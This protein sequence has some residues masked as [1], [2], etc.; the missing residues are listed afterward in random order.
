LVDSEP[1]VPYDHLP[2]RSAPKL[3]ARSVLLFTLFVST[4]VSS[5]FGVTRTWTGAVSATWS[6][7]GNWSPA[8]VPSASDAL[9]FPAAASNKST[10]NDLGAGFVVGALSFEGT[11]TL[12][13][14]SL[15][16]LGDVNATN[17][18]AV[19]L[20]INAGVKLGASLHLVSGYTAFTGAVDVNGKVLSIDNNGTS[21]QGALNGSGSVSCPDG[22]AVAVAHGSFSGTLACSVSSQFMQLSNGDVLKPDSGFLIGYGTIGAVNVATVRATAELFTRS[23]TINMGAFG[24]KVGHNSTG[25]VGVTGTVTLNSPELQVT[26]VNGGGSSGETYVIIQNDGVDPII[27]TF[28]GLPEGAGVTVGGERYSISYRGGNGASVALTYRSRTSTT[29]SQSSA[30]SRYGEPVTLIATTQSGSGG[31][32]PGSLRFMD[33][34]SVLGT[35]SPQPSQSA[36]LNVASLEPGAHS[37]TASYLGSQYFD[38]STSTPVS[39]TVLRGSTNCSIASNRASALYGEVVRFNVAV[40]AQAPA[41]GQPAGTV[42]ILE[43]GAAIG[44]APVAGGLA[45]L[46]ARLRPGTKSITAAY[47]GDVHFE[48]SSSAAITQTVGKAPTVI[49]TGLRNP[50]YIGS[51]ATVNLTVKATTTSLFVP[52]GE[53]SVTEGAVLLA[54]QTLIGGSAALNLGTLPAGAH[55][56]RVA[57][58]GSQDFEPSSTTAVQVVLVPAISIAGTRVMEGTGGTTTFALPITLSAPISLPVRVSFFTMP[59]TATEGADYEKTAGVIEF[60]PGEQTKT[61]E[62]HVVADP[63]LENDETFSVLL[64]SPTG[65]TLDVASAVVVIANDDSPPARR[66][67]SRH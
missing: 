60:A 63:L 53:V 52:A 61:I 50:L 9:T 1:V 65:A 8:G 56:L 2:V 27:G 51:A 6:N 33:G 11:Y 40:S 55:E 43:D 67:P 4:F 37:V 20:T 7:S 12:N 30:T 45:S 66:R 42:T 48:A 34:G 62:V 49:E 39:H 31:G 38:E 13:G 18:Q 41:A 46:E 3:M 47:A 26:L 16:L 57:Y 24:V 10:T 5:A 17:A 28:A 35:V 29:L 25:K 22:V 59:G 44:T 54:R 23:L 15:V 19:T 14:D 32:V 58:Q 36:L 64:L 21:F